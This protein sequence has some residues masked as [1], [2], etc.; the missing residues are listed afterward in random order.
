MTDEH[1]SGLQDIS[2]QSDRPSVIGSQ[3]I[4]CNAVQ[5]PARARC[6]TCG[7]SEEEQ[8]R[9][10]FDRR[11]TVESYS[12][13]Y[14][15]HPGFEPPYTVGY[16]RLSPGEVRVFT[17]LF[18][19]AADAVAIGSVVEIAVETLENGYRTWGATLLEESS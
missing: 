7:A 9:M 13:I 15:P 4:A 12:E 11:A 6:S 14:T 2:F 18:G 5:F 10:T 19:V 3:C 16:I 1:S 8:T 17:P